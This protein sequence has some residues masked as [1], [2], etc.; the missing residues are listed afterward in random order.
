[1]GTP[2]LDARD[3]TTVLLAMP[4]WMQH[5]Q[6]RHQ[7]LSPLCVCAIENTHMHT[8]FVSIDCDQRPCRYT[9]GDDAGASPPSVFAR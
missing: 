8:R 4:V 3:L 9:P 2:V 1:M 7:L 5:R 6:L